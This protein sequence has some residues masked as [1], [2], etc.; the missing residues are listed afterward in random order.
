MI[1][2]IAE[3][4]QKDGQDISWQIGP[5]VLTLLLVAAEWGFHIYLRG[6]T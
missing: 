1:L 3:W 6:T 2:R 5:A 4:F